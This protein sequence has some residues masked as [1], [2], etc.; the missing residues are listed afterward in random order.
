[1]HWT[2]V[3]EFGIEGKPQ[4]FNLDLPGDTDGGEGVGATGEEL[5][6]AQQQHSDVVLTLLLHTRTHTCISNG[7]LLH[8]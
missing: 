3:L 2:G 1:M 6:F 7:H 5:P 4:N 8:F